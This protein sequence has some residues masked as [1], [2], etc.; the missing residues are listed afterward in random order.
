METDEAMSSD[1]ALDLEEEVLKLHFMFSYYVLPLI[2]Q[3]WSVLRQMNDFLEKK[4]VPSISEP[5][6]LEV[7]FL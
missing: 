7:P 2:D 4:K 5:S 3:I 6:H 1:S